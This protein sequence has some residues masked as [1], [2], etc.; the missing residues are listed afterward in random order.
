MQ[1]VHTGNC[2]FC[3]FVG[4]LT[5]EHVWPKW[6]TE[7]AGLPLTFKAKNHYH[8]TSLTSLTDQ[9]LKQLSDSRTR[10]SGD[11]G[12][13]KLWIACSKCNG[14]WMSTLQ[15]K[16]KSFIATIVNGGWPQF[17]EHDAEI[18]A[19][20]CIMTTM[21][22]EFKDLKTIAIPPKE[23]ANLKFSH[24][25]LGPEWTVLIGRCPSELPNRRA[26]HRGYSFPMSGYE[27]GP[28]QPTAQLTTLHVGQLLVQV[29]YSPDDVNSFT[30]AYSDRSKMWPLHPALFG[31]DDSE[32]PSG[33]SK[34]IE[35]YQS[36]LIDHYEEILTFRHMTTPP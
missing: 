6:L 17:N 14:G 35:T 9:G 3:D 30:A 2:E 7:F 33:E 28:V 8:L 22:W 23:R 25:P 29:I 26:A 1:H 12:S 15:H 32:R 4:V 11:P 18:I 19:R 21:V 24:I 5:D 10:R 34:F 27:V 36:N 20:W 31:F 13:V 16:A